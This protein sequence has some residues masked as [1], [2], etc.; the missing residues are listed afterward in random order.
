MEH[1]NQSTDDNGK[2]A[3][4]ELTRAKYGSGRLGR[5]SL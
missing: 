4:K 1:E 2:A 5:N 3:S